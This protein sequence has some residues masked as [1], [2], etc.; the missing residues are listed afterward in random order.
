MMKR[1]LSEM[2]ATMQHISRQNLVNVSG[3]IG[4]QIAKSGEFSGTL[5]PEGST[6]LHLLR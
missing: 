4:Q 6:G 1:T 3:E 5:V 2:L